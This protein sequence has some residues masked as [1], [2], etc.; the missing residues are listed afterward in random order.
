MKFK[1]T[2]AKITLDEFF[3]LNFDEN[4]LWEY[5]ADDVDLLVDL[6]N[7]I[8]PVN[9]KETTEVDI[10]GLNALL[11]EN[12]NYRDALAL[13]LSGILKN[14]KFSKILTD[15]GILTDA[16]FIYEVKKRLIIT[17]F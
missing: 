17:L 15:A 10:S 5:K 4:N 11:G 13:Y 2:K 9:P 6:V 3:K 14:K 7:I 12:E 16:D 1:K 8:R